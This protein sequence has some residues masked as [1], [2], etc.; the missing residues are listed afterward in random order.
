MLLT[1]DTL[2]QDFIQFTSEN[3]SVKFLNRHELV[4]MV[5]FFLV[6][7]TIHD[8]HMMKFWTRTI[9]S[10]RQ[11]WFPKENILV[12]FFFELLLH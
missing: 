2:M 8:S 9:T 4:S 1:V 3:N 10:V 6:W 12:E 5:T 7:K 11:M